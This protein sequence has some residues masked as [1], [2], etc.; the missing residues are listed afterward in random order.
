MANKVLVR[1]GIRRSDKMLTKAQVRK[2]A[3]LAIFEG[4]KPGANVSNVVEKLTSEYPALKRQDQQR[5]VIRA[6]DPQAPMKQFHKVLLET[7][8][9]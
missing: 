4:N 2:I 1:Q 3:K 9:Q 5:M 7:A 8:R 6:I